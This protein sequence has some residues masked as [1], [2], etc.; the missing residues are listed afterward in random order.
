MRGWMPRSGAMRAT[1]A[2]PGRH[3]IPARSLE[4]MRFRRGMRFIEHD[5]KHVARLI[6]RHHRHEV[7]Q[8][9]GLE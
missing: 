1:T 9:L 6:G 3:G 8:H 4:A 5:Q 7:G 2:A